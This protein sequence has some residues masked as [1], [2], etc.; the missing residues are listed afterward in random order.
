[1]NIQDVP[2]VITSEDYFD[3]VGSAYAVKVYD[4]WAAEDLVCIYERND[5]G[6]NLVTCAAANHMRNLVDM[7]EDTDG[8]WLHP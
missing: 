6:W 3:R 5:S 2:Q 4:R 1:M 7:L 8:T